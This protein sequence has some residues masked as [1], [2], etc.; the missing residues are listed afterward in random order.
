M[1]DK[2]YYCNGFQTS[3]NT[4]QRL[5]MIRFL[6][7]VPGLPEDLNLQDPGQLQTKVFPNTVCSQ[8]TVM[9]DNEGL[10]NLIDSLLGIQKRLENPQSLSE[11]PFNG[12]E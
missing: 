9:L 11:E 8:A 7:Q 12:R 5:T 6:A 4:H 10:N 1:N 2:V 3:Y